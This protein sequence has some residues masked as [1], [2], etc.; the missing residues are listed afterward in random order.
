MGK[1]EKTKR[2][3]INQFEIKYKVSII[4]PFPSV[5]PVEPSIIRISHSRSRNI[6]YHEYFDRFLTELFSTNSNHAD[7]IFIVA[8]I[9]ASASWKTLLKSMDRRILLFLKSMVVIRNIYIYVMW[10]QMLELVTAEYLAPVRK[11]MTSDHFSFS[12]MSFSRSLF[13]FSFMCWVRLHYKHVGIILGRFPLELAFECNTNLDGISFEIICHEN[14]WNNQRNFLG[15]EK[16]TVV[17]EK[18][19]QI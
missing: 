11:Q 14:V 7:W 3:E 12:F 19:E 2:V 1:G 10:K 17:S 9:W 18:M 4:S 16:H 8:C 5:L 15:I 13:S 6:L